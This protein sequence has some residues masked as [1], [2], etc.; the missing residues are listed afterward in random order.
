MKL[1]TLFDMPL[2]GKI[3]QK[4][5]V[6][7]ENGE[8]NSKTIREYYKNRHK[9]NVGLYSYGCFTNGF[10]YANGGKVNIGRYCS[11]G[12][13]V[14]YLGAN[15][16]ID[17]FST[18]PLFYRNIYGYNVEDVPRAEIY[19]GDDVWIG[20]NVNITSNCNNIGIGA[21]IA[22]GAVVTKD[23]PPYAIVGGGTC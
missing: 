21:C 13:N 8:M 6:R 22:A 23:I 11:F 20:T 7:L 2:I 19:I 15:H 3:F 17:R 14:H 10:N 12:S 5:V 1:Y 4:L 16:P 18:S 9:M